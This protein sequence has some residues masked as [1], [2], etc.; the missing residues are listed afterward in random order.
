MAAGGLERL[1][2]EGRGVMFWRITKGKQDCMRSLD[3]LCAS[4]SLGV[5][6]TKR[7]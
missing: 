4:R 1:Q 2:G 6:V 3:R 5:E 7:W